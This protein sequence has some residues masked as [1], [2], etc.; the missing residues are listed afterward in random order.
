M[1]YAN[2]PFEELD[3]MNNFMFNQLSTNPKTKEG[4][5]RCLI[6]NLLG[7]ETSKIIIRA[8]NM[9]YPTL[10]DKRGVRLDVQVDE[11][12]KHDKLTTIYDIEPHRDSE[13]AYPRRFGSP[14]HRL[15]RTICLVVAMIFPICPIC[16][17]LISPTTIH[18]VTIKW[19][20]LSKINVSKNRS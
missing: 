9:I 8:E 3:V 7:I 4:F 10:P 20:T 12:D 19:F 14:G 11:L 17:S 6:K 1:S 5:L 2:E 15:I 18:S 16:I 13:K